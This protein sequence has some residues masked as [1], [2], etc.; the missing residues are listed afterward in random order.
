V[1]TQYDHGDPTP[2]EQL[3]LELL[4]RAR[5]NPS[6][7]AASF[8]IDLNANLSPGTISPNPKPPLA[9][10]PRLIQAARAH[11]DW[12]LATD[13]F[14][15][16]GVTNSTPADRIRNAGY[17]VS[18]SWAM[19][20]NI[21]W[22]GTTGVADLTQ[23]TL[24]E[25]E[26]LFRSAGHRKNLLDPDFDEVGVGVR[27]GV[28]SQNGKDFDS[29]MIAQEFARSSGTPGPLVIG[30]VFRDANGDGHYT[31][32]EGVGGLTVTPAAGGYWAV[33]SASG[34]FAVPVTANAGPTLVTISG[35]GVVVPLARAVTV[36]TVNVKVDFDLATDVPLSL[37]STTAGF[38]AQDH[39]HC[40]LRGPVNARARVQFA[41]SVGQWEELGIFT[42]V[43]GK[44]GIVDGRSR[45]TRAFYRAEIVP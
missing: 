36:G 33:T 5:A 43:A 21:A 31:A 23:F 29:V 11:A 13:T 15:H 6:A 37:I 39:F 17:P 44:A 42:L 26:G 32:G 20:E 40:E 35:P 19:G 41:T 22:Q 28:Y 18:G 1:G 14:S 2:Q 4:N 45:Q 27:R 38:D 16:T 8:G 9:F 24:D 25:H 12:M 10:Q 3:M 34:G 30:V 7:E